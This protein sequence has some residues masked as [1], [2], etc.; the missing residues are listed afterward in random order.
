MCMHVSSRFNHPNILRLLG[1]CVLNEPH[2]LIL[3]LM[4]GGD[5][6]MYLRGARATYVSTGCDCI[7]LKTPNTMFKPDNFPY[8]CFILYV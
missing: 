8:K 3:E 5:L 7:V 4:E 2:Y 1:V 6:R